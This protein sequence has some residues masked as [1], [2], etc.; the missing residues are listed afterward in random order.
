MV[1]VCH[2]VDIQIQVRFSGFIKTSGANK[3]KELGNI[4]KHEAGKLSRDR[5]TGMN[6]TRPNQETQ[7]RQ[8]DKTNHQ[9]KICRTKTLQS[10]TEGKTS[11]KAA[12]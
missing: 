10:N 11:S 5:Q 3:T 6:Q 8:E 1:L 9:K 4:Q 7:S 2:E 12:V